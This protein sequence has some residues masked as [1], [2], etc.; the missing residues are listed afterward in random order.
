MVICLG[1]VQ[2]LHMSHL[3][4]LP[5]TVSCSSKSTESFTILV[6]AY[7]GCPGKKAIKRMCVC[8]CCATVNRASPRKGMSCSSSMPLS[9]SL[10]SPA[11]LAANSAT[12][13]SS[14]PGVMNFCINFVPLYRILFVMLCTLYCQHGT[15]VANMIVNCNRYLY[16]H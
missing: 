13:T 7:P 15:A 1:R 16:L 9:A 5:L 3:M 10:Q 6:P 12:T 11:T 14:T 8:V 2:F 4:P